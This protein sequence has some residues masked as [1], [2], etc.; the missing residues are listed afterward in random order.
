MKKSVKKL[1][2][3]FLTVAMAISMTACGS[4]GAPASSGGGNSTEAGG[5]SAAPGEE[6]LSSRDTLNMACK[7]EPTSLDPAQT[8]DLVTWMFMYNVSDSL[9]YFN[10]ET[11]EY[12][13]A[14]AT[15]WTESDDGME[16][17]FTIR[18]GVKFHNGDTMTTDDVVFSLNRAIAS[19]FTAQTNACIDH[20]EKVDD[21]H[22]KAVLKYAY[23]PFLEI[24]TNPAYSIVSQKAVEECEAAGRDFG[25][26]PVGVGA[27]KLKSWQS[28]NRLEFERHDDYYRGTPKM[29]NINWTIITDASAGAMALEAGEIDYYYG[30]S[31][32]DYAHLA[33]M[34][35]LT[36]VVENRGFGLYDITFNTTDGPFTDINLR[37][38]VAYAINRQEILQGGAEGLGEV[39]NCW[40]ATGA[41]GYLSDFEWY[42]QDLDKA[43]ECLAAAGYP[44]GIDI[45]FTQDS[46]DTYMAPAE[47]MQAQ[48]AQ[49]GINVTFEKLQR[50]VWIE[51]VSGNRQ[52]QASL[53]MTNHV[54][55]DAEYM[56]RRRLT[57]EMLGGGNNYSGYQNPEFD[58][59]VDASVTET[60]NAKR[61]DIF[62]QCYQMI[63][64]DLP[65]IPLYTQSTTI[66]I[67]KNIHGWTFHPLERN[68]WA[69]AYLVEE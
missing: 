56:L 65:V 19:S 24:M 39:N 55:N 3:M 4:S 64:D 36:T 61:M 41:T 45:V 46:S 38:A 8:K 15:E 35:N 34:P 51:T 57:T 23:A 16:Y 50:S 32:A 43:K 17:N 37:K 28:G 27:Y 11:Q 6:K 42:E 7:S 1:L 2:A 29:K 48:L 49:V 30:L 53:R 21:T 14:I 40:C 25:R 12:E 60:D 33:E 10:W 18:E 59:L 13:P 26:E 9:L 20:F 69:N 58:K 63:K 62:R 52:F 44:N 31:K 67:N 66:V 47:V 5:G 68:V 54:I 22:V